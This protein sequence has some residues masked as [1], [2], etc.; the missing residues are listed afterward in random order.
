MKST[1]RFTQGVTVLNLHSFNLSTTELRNW[2]NREVTAFVS[3]PPKHMITRPCVLGIHS[4]G[5]QNNP[6]PQPFP[7]STKKK[8]KGKNVFWN[9][10]QS[11][12]PWAW[13]PSFLPLPLPLALTLWAH[14]VHQTGRR[15]IH[16]QKANYF[17]T[18]Q[19]R[20]QIKHQL[21]KEEHKEWP[22][23]LVASSYQIVSNLLKLLP[24]S[25]T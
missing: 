9:K 24:S 22:I 1:V 16:Q 18:A 13:K 6:S 23:L 15:L 14:S 11:N 19:G 21:M 7:N 4:E 10:N 3:L 17:L 20:S 12:R 2:S 25:T 8:K 5:K